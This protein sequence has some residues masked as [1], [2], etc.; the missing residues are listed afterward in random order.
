MSEQNA[1]PAA[2]EDIEGNG[3]ALPAQGI[4]KS[5]Q[6]KLLKMQ[7]FEEKKLAKRAEAKQKKQEESQK[8]Q[9]ELAALLEAM[10]SGEREAWNAKRAE[11]R[12]A[13]KEQGQEKRSRL[14]Q[15]Q[16][17]GQQVVVDLGFDDLMTELE[18]KSLAKQ[19]VYCHSVNSRAAAP[20]HLIFTDFEG[21]IAAQLTAQSANHGQWPVTKHTA[22]YADAFRDRREKL[23]YLTADA[24]EELHQL[25][26]ESIYIIGGLVDRNRYK[27]I[28]QS[29]AAEQGIRTARLPIR[30]HMTMTGTHVLTVN[31]GGP[32]E[33]SGDDLRIQSNGAEPALKA[34]QTDEQPS[35]KR[36]KIEG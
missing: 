30:E 10:S 26:S 34:A 27:N 19:L 3:A 24:T 31:Q 21:T 28:C 32:S 22:S 11:V 4:S 16:T 17:Q 29:K 5:K 9:A 1:A 20:C 25:D 18:L 12:Q 36:T 14:E 15:A 7:R 6:K 33:T 23:V 13:R 2:A 35:A 8:R